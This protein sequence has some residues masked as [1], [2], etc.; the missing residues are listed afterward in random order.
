MK[1][2]LYTRITW[3]GSQFTE[4]TKQFNKL[5]LNHTQYIYSC[6]ITSCNPPAPSPNTNTYIQGWSFVAERPNSS[7]VMTRIIL[8]P[9]AHPD[10]QAVSNPL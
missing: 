1:S 8:Q 9:H 6:H 3:G 7:L 10:L 2:C 5:T 4:L